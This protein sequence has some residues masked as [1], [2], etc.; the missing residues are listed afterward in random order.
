[1][2]LDDRD[3]DA[4][5]RD[6]MPAALAAKLGSTN[7]NVASCAADGDVD[8]HIGDLVHDAYVSDDPD[9]TRAG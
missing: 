2:A 4:G 1:M 7:P 5:F 9:D 8:L 3:A 6:S